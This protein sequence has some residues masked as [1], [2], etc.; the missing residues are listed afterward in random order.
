MVGA[1]G[2]IVSP[3]F[4]AETAPP[5]P[6]PVASNRPPAGSVGHAPAGPRGDVVGAALICCD[7]AGA[8][9]RLSWSQAQGELIF[10]VSRHSH[11]IAARAPARTS[12][13]VAQAGSAFRHGLPEARRALDPLQRRLEALGGRIWAS[14]GRDPAFHFSLG[15]ACRLGADAGIRQGQETN[16]AEW[17]QQA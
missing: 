6:L 2:R 8:E 14:A 13:W 15:S 3:R 7:D 10:T 11:G 12:S 4:R 17:R 16:P 9:L 5:A 1:A